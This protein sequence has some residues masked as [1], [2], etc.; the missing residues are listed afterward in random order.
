MV[1]RLHGYGAWIE[2]DSIP[3]E[4]YAVKVEGNIISCYVCSEEGKVRSSAAPCVLRDPSSP[5]TRC[6][7]KKFVLHFDDD[8]SHSSEHTTPDKG[9]GRTIVAKMDGSLV[10]CLWGDFKEKITSEG[11]PDG[12]I[13]RPYLFAPINTT[14]SSATPSL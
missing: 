13:I 2:T 14:G 12:D 5:L 9:Y 8:G 4:E 3:L 1:L 7:Y 11:M 10:S 6:V